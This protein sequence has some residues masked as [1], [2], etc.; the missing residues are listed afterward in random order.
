MADRYI[1]TTDILI[2]RGDLCV[3][4]GVLSWPQGSREWLVQRLRGTF[5][6]Q[7]TRRNGW[8][9]PVPLSR[10][11]PRA[12]GA[13]PEICADAAE[14]AGIVKVL[15]QLAHSHNAISRRR[16]LAISATVG[17]EQYGHITAGAAMWFTQKPC[18]EPVQTGAK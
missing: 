12:Y 5:R 9:R 17:D 13:A 18:S 10:D 8:R 4:V 7:R 1:D 11:S 14:A 6:G 16:V 3:L 2:V 15:P